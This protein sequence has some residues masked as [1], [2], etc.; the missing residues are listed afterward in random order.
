M[1]FLLGIAGN[2]SELEASDPGALAVL[3]QF[4]QA[5][6]GVFATGDHENL[7][8]ALCARIPRVRAMRL[9]NQGT[10]SFDGIDRLSTNAPGRSDQGGNDVYEFG[11]Q[12]DLL[13]ELSGL[14]TVAAR[15]EPVTNIAVVRLDE[16]DI[17]RH[18][19]VAEMLG[20]L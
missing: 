3:T 1:V 7:G 17:V 18:P 4:M 13:P 10:P 12:S 20:V 15:L 16:A 19:L 6:G 9:W 14:A 11:D 5:G 8:A 2:Y